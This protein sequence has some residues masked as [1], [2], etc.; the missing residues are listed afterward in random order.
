MERVLL[1]FS[2][3]RQADRSKKE[4]ALL[5]YQHCTRPFNGII[6]EL[7]Y[8]F[9]RQSSADEVDHSI[10]EHYTK[11]FFA[12][13]WFGLLSFSIIRV[14]VHIVRSVYS[15]KLFAFLQRG[16]TIASTQTN[17]VKAK[18]SPKTDL[19]LRL[20]S[21][22]GSNDIRGPELMFLIQSSWIEYIGKYAL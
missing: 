8:A 13:E 2:I 12:G 11:A 7:G 22:T 10:K 5:Q 3:K 21:G 15:V 17:P 4:F 20:C 16:H 6:K 18:T 14:V 9:F 19:V 1:F